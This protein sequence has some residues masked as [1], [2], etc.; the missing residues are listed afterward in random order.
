MCAVDIVAVAAKN[1]GDLML[2]IWVQPTKHADAELAELRPREAELGRV[3][4]IS[5]SENQRDSFGQL[6]LNMLK[7]FQNSLI[8]TN[9]ARGPSGANS[10]SAVGAACQS[11]QGHAGTFVCVRLDCYGSRAV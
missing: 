9:A 8:H 11:C 10:Q 6:R 4:L 7:G 5:S 1:I 3:G 2:P